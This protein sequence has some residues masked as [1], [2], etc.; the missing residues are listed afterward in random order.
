MEKVKVFKYGQ[1]TLDDWL[2]EFELNLEENHIKT[3]E[4]KIAWCLAAIGPVARLYIEKLELNSMWERIKYQLRLFLGKGNPTLEKRNTMVTS[5][6]K[7][8]LAHDVDKVTRTDSVSEGMEAEERLNIG[9]N[10]GAYRTLG[11]EPWNWKFNM[12]PEALRGT[13]EDLFTYDE[14]SQ[15]S[16]ETS[17]EGEE[18]D[19]AVEEDREDPADMGEE[20]LNIFRNIINDLEKKEER[21]EKKEKRRKKKEKRRKKK[22]ER[23]IVMK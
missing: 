9:A 8:P 12:L 20:G 23:R 1:V 4:G 15:G 10:N 13:C 5:G 16:Y 11:T 22:E 18:Y 7:G 17:S 3:D 6:R 2:N 19:S 21:K 14:E